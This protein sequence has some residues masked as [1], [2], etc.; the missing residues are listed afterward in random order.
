MAS[1]GAFVFGGTAVGAAA[2]GG[3]PLTAAL[4]API[5][6]P[7]PQ[8][9]LGGLLPPGATHGPLVGSSDASVLDR[10]ETAPLVAVGT[11]PPP[12]FRTRGRPRG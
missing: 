2:A 7:T 11:D 3:A 1:G 12:S 6:T 4:S 8:S 5:P 10:V 9:V